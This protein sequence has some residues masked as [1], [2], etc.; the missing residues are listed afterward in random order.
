MRLIMPLIYFSLILTLLFIIFEFVFTRRRAETKRAGLF[1]NFTF[2]LIILFIFFFQVFQLSLFLI[3]NPVTITALK[4]TVDA[5]SSTVWFIFIL[6]FA[7]SMYF[8]YRICLLYTSPSP[9]DR[10]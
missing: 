2:S 8:L 6:E 1:D 5:S 4:A 9:R 7:V 3:L 10:S